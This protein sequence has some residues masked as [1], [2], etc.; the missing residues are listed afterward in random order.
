MKLEKFAPQTKVCRSSWRKGLYAIR[1]MQGIWQYIDNGNL[2][3]KLSKS[4]LEYPDFEHYMK[5]YDWGLDKCNNCNKLEMY[6]TCKN[7]NK[8][9][10]IMVNIN[11]VGGEY[12]VVKVKFLDGRNSCN[13]KISVDIS[14]EE[15]A[16]VVV[17]SVNGLGLARVITA[18]ANNFENVEEITKAKAWVVN[19]VDEQDHINRVKASE[20]REYVIKQLEERREAMQANEVYEMLGEADPIAKKLLEQLKKLV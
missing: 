19:V 4:M 2:A 8:E 18:Y 6:C 20:K 7:K 5:P 15:R 11:F 1:T 13:Y 12:N 16:L 17:H 9:E 14:I 3:G 10:S